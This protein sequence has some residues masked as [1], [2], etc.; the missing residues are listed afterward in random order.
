M[1]LL[2][3]EVAFG[4]KVTHLS[5]VSETVF[6]YKIGVRLALFLIHG[7]PC[8]AHDLGDMRKLSIR[9]PLS[10]KSQVGLDKVHE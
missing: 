9:V 4:E 8:L 5:L 6:L 3:G 10:H 1:T 2:G 7:L